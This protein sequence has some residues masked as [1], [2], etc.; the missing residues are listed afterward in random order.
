MTARRVSDTADIPTTMSNLNER[1]FTALLYAYV[2]ELDLDGFGTLVVT[3]W[4]VIFK[5]IWFICC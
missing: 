2:T 1:Q 4:L 5:F 3:R